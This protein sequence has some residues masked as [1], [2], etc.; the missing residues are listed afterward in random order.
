MDS[1]ELTF[2]ILKAA[3][4]LFALINIVPVMAWVERRGMALMQRRLGPNRVGPFGLLQSLADAVKFI[5]KED[6]APGHVNRF[7]YHLAPFI[8]VVPAFMAFAVIPFAS[9][10]EL[11]GRIVEF[12]VADLNVGLLY[13]FAIGSLAV[14]GLMLGAWSSNSKYALFGGLRGTAQMVSYELAMGLSI[15]GLI[16]TFSSV[17]LMTIV[18]SQGEMWQLG[19]I[20]VPKWGIFLQPLGGLIFLIALFAETNRLPFD[21]A[22]GESEIVAGYHLEYGSMKFALFMMAEYVHL[23]TASALMATLYFGGWQFLPGMA[24]MVEPLG[25]FLYWAYSGLGEFAPFLPFMGQELATDWARVFME[26]A[27]FSIKVGAFLWFFVHVRWSLPRFRYDQAM[28]FG[29]KV[30]LPLSLANI[31]LTGLMIYW[32]VI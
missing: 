20:P 25:G 7:Y 9:S 10:I 5:F 28:F 17:D 26:V 21:F 6:R 16:M 23:T 13:V 24:M 19:P 27:S 29:W 32:N 18:R 14:Y 8:A 15:I 3:I 11:S 31:G 4:V 2:A 12:Q 30:L 22:E 1:F